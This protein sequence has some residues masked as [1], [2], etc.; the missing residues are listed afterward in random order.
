MQQITWQ[1]FEKIEFR[2]GTIVEAKNF[3][4]AERLFD[5]QMYVMLMKQPD[6]RLGY[7]ED[8]YD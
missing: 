8:G 6:S 4:E 3:P 2:V 1:D 7:L 5:P